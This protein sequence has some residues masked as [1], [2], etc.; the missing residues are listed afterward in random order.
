MILVQPSFEADIIFAVSGLIE[1]E[2]Q[3]ALIYSYLIRRKLYDKVRNTSING[4]NAGRYFRKGRSKT[5]YLFSLFISSVSSK[6]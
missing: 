2:N 4:S 6:T 1:T 5:W 3:D